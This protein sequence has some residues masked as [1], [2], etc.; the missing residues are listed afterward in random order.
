M[1]SSFLLVLLLLTSCHRAPEDQATVRFLIESSPNNL[2]LRQGTD[3][4]SERIGALV[5]EGLAK[6]DEHFALQPWLAASWERPVPLTWVFPLR[7]GMWPGPS[8]A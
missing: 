4:Q 3:A 6:K 8:A 5:Y 7:P 2:D 1:L